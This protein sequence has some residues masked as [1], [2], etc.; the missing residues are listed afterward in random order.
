MRPIN[1][2]GYKRGMGMMICHRKAGN[3]WQRHGAKASYKARTS[4]GNFSHVQSQINPIQIIVLFFF[5]IFLISS[6]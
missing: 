1:G 3:F 4:I 5:C 6:F 2:N